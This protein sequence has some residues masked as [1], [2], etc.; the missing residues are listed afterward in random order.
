M[1]QKYNIIT[2]KLDLNSDAV[3][4]FSQPSEVHWGDG[5]K[6]VALKVNSRCF[7]LY[8]VD[9]ISFNSTWMLANS[10]A[11]SAEACGGAGGA[12]PPNN[13]EKKV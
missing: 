6:K 12:C 13:F 10:S 7:K 11:G 8:M 1:Y 9:S 3:R 2:N 5:Y 4:P